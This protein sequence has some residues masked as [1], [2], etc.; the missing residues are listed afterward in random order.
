V[1]SLVGPASLPV[2]PHSESDCKLRES[3]ASNEGAG[4]L[5]R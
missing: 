3:G 5:A 2:K 4:S 1:H